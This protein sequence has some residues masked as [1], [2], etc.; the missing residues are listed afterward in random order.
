M[1]RIERKEDAK[2]KDGIFLT[3]RTVFVF[4]NHLCTQSLSKTCL[5]TPRIVSNRNRVNSHHRVISFKIYTHVYPYNLKIIYV[6]QQVDSYRAIS[7]KI[8]TYVYPHNLKIIYVEWQ[9]DSKDTV[10]VFF[11]LKN[12]I[13][14]VFTITLE[15]I[16]ESRKFVLLCNF[17]QSKY[18][19]IFI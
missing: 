8:Y 3:D 11:I 5:I 10:I 15:R 19:R 12:I 7:F 1:K 18:T 13:P 9:L 17:F 2:K 14:L 6:E 4:L 16:R